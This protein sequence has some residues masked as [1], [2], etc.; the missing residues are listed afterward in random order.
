MRQVQLH[1]TPT[2]GTSEMA[3]HARPAIPQSPIPTVM[4]GLFWLGSTQRTQ[5]GS[6]AH[7]L[8]MSQ[9][10]L[11][12]LSRQPSPKTEHLPSL[13]GRSVALSGKSLGS[14]TDHML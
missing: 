10:S 9:S 4:R 3:S 7:H 6:R 12:R 13:L 8:E 1:P 14:L 2:A 5:R 11:A